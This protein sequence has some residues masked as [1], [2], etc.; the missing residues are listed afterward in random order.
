M[1]YFDISEAV[2]KLKMT[3]PQPTQNRFIYVRFLSWLN[4]RLKFWVILQLGIPIFW[5]FNQYKAARAGGTGNEYELDEV[6]N[7]F[8]TV[9]EAE[10]Q[11][12]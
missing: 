9:D 5:I 10:Y 7:V 2:K 12:I 3:K 4:L 6:E 8:D 1:R 11:V